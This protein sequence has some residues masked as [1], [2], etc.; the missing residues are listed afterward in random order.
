MLHPATER[1]RWECGFGGEGR[2]SGVGP[3]RNLGKAA[4][5][6]ARRS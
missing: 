5:C 2:G 3:H 4:E 6:L 1:V